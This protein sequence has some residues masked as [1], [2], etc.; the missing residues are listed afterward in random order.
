MERLKFFPL[1]GYEDRHM[2]PDP[3]INRTMVDRM[4]R[5]QRKRYIDQCL[6]IADWNDPMWSTKGID[7]IIGPDV[8]RRDHY[9]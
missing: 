9:V 2:D 5:D 3:C 1:A 6:P 8:T 7:P 4:I